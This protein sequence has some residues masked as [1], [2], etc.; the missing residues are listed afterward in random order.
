MAPSLNATPC[1]MPVQSRTLVHGTSCES[2]CGFF[3]MQERAQISLPTFLW[4]RM[5]M[6]ATYRFLILSL[7]LDNDVQIK[8]IKETS[9]KKRLS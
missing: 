2:Q 9:L 1:E 3:R 5:K 7:L 8:E 6:F 4:K